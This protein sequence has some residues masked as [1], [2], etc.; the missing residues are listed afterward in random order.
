MEATYGASGREGELSE[1]VEENEQPDY[2]HSGAI[3]KIHSPRLIAIE[4][5]PDV[6]EGA[7]LQVILANQIIEVS[8]VA[9]KDVGRL[10]R[11]D[12]EKRLP[13]LHGGLGL[14]Q[15]W[16]VFLGGDGFAGSGIPSAALDAR[17]EPGGDQLGPQARI[18][19]DVVGVAADR[20]LADVT[21]SA[22]SK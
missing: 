21:P 19:L 6:L 22:A 2:W 7:L 1:I 5:H 10:L 13:I 17:I 14:F 4:L 12:Q 20:V 16:L 15:Q 9:P 8:H 3:P 11:I 18:M